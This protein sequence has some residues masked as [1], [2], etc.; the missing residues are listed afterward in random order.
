MEKRIIKNYRFFLVGSY[1]KAHYNHRTPIYKPAESTLQILSFFF[2]SDSLLFRI[3][4]K[5]WSHPEESLTT[6]RVTFASVVVFAPTTHPPE[7][8]QKSSRAVR[9][10]R[11]RPHRST[12]TRPRSSTSSSTAP[13]SSTAGSTARCPQVCQLT[14]VFKVCGPRPTSVLHFLCCRWC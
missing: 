7:A 11:G 8:R 10:H 6:A 13:P 2:E 14:S 3:S 1:G 9:E 5:T 4:S 12:R